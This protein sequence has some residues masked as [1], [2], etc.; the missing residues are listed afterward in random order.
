MTNFLLNV[1]VFFCTTVVLCLVLLAS[2]HVRD[3]PHANKMKYTQ[4]SLSRNIAQVQPNAQGNDL[5]RYRDDA[6]HRKW[7]NS[8][9]DLHTRLSAEIPVSHIDPILENPRK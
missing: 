2:L 5:E 6:K 8:F 1:W 7:K 4:N 3:M 9:R